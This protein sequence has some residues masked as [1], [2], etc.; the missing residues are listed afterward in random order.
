MN[1]TRTIIL[2]SVRGGY[3]NLPKN[4]TKISEQVK[5][6]RENPRKLTEIFE[7]TNLRWIASKR[8]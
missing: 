3:G 6:S 5:K 4:F 2:A 7:K 1:G 8:K